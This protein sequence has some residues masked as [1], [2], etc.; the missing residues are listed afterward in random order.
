MLHSPAAHIGDPYFISCDCHSAHEAKTACN[1]A[2]TKSGCRAKRKTLES[3]TIGGGS[4]LVKRCR[5]RKNRRGRSAMGHRLR[6]QNQKDK[7]KCFSHKL[8]CLMTGSR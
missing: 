1:K 3:G 2:G 5:R 7:K 8:I 6:S 4:I